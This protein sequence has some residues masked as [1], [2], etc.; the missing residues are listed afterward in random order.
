MAS[1]KHDST[2]T[3]QVQGFYAGS[4]FGMHKNDVV[5]TTDTLCICSEGRSH[6]HLTLI[7]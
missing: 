1:N 6:S 3:K 4:V 2:L 5:H 7:L